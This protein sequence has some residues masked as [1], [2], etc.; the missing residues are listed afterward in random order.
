MTKAEELTVLPK[1]QRWRDKLGLRD[2]LQ[3]MKAHTEVCEC[4]SFSQ[5]H[6]AD[7]KCSQ[8]HVSML[9]SASLAHFGNVILTKL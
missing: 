3:G 8:L 2:P 4:D 7:L 1:E 6:L 9:V 5:F